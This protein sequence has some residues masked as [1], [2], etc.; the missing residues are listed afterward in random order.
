MNDRN[1]CFHCTGLEQQLNQQSKLISQLMRIIAATNKRVSM[2][3]NRFPEVTSE[4]NL[5]YS[6]PDTPSCR[7]E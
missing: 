3:E 5:T 6:F 7:I 4:P 2:L 1:Q